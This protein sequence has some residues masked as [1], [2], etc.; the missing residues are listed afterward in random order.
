MWWLLLACANP[1]P[2]PGWGMDAVEREGAITVSAVEPGGFAHTTGLL[3]GDRL[4]AWQQDEVDRLADLGPPGDWGVL[5]V[6]RLGRVQSLRWGEPPQRHPLIGQPAPP[7]ALRHLEGGA[8]LALAA[9]RGRVVVVDFWASWCAPCLEAI[10]GLNA[11]VDAHPP[12]RLAVLSVALESPEAAR[13]V[14]ERLRTV[15]LVA[16]P[17]EVEQ[18]W[19]VRGIPALYVLDPEGVVRAVLEGAEEAA[20]APAWVD[21]LL[22]TPPTEGPP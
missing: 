10:P 6:L 15:R 16:S 21:R 1:T 5:D 4:L 17:S 11:L 14:A 7:L 18:A 13:P 19:G 12:E 2:V 3:P 20:R 9:L 22:N 8:E